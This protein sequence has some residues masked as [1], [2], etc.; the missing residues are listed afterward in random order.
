[1]LWPYLQIQAL[2]EECF[3]DEDIALALNNLP[4]DLSEAYDR[5]LIRIA[6]RSAKHRHLARRIFSWVACSS[7]PLM[8]DELQEAIA[9]DEEDQSWNSSKIPSASSVINCSANLIA[10]DTTD[11]Y[12]RFV[13][14]SVGNYLSKGLSKVFGDFQIH[15]ATDRLRCGEY[16]VN[17]LSFSDF[18]FQVQLHPTLRLNRADMPHPMAIAAHSVNGIGSVLTNFRLRRS[19]PAA[20]IMQVKVPAKPVSATQAAFGSFRLLPYARQYWSRDTKLITADSPRWDK[21]KTLALVPNLTWE[22]QPWSSSGQSLISYLHGLLGHA[23]E[24]GHLAL[25]D[26]LESRQFPYISDERYHLS[27]YCNLPLNSTESGLCALHMASR[28]GNV[29][30]VERLLLYSRVN[31]QDERGNAALHYASE[32]GHG[33]VVHLIV[34][35]KGHV[36]LINTNGQTPLHLSVSHN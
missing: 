34:S 1:M 35:H 25:F 2:W 27:H 5:C 30:L 36:N 18:T 24:L 11:H 17:Y 19:K 23:V 21:F 29:Q 22:L 6:K 15:P 7:R 32:K 3:T 14:S 31:I 33:N 4:K 13:H 8:L 10:V 12:V 28:A 16:C 26:L 20:P 9:F